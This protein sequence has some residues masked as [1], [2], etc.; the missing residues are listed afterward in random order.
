MR[1]TGLSSSCKKVYKLQWV[2]KSATSK[3]RSLPENFLSPQGS[4]MVAKATLD[5]FLE[6]NCPEFDRL[7]LSESPTKMNE[8]LVFTEPADHAQNYLQS[9]ARF[10]KSLHPRAIETLSIQHDQGRILNLTSIQEK[11]APYLQQFVPNHSS[12]KH[13]PEPPLNGKHRTCSM[14]IPRQTIKDDQIKPKCGLVLPLTI[15]PKL[16]LDKDMMFPIEL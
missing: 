5:D 13:Q 11:L 8:Y 12:P 7:T 2:S 3:P 6:D 9:L 16:T 10:I 4:K 14:K 1:L 15:N